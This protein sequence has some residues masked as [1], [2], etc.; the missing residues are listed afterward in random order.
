MTLSSL[1]V[2]GPG[3]LWMISS[4]MN[5]F[6]YPVGQACYVTGVAGQILI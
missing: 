4:G 3:L 5:I 1:F 6:P 2:S